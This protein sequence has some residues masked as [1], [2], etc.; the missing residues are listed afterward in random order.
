MNN[1]NDGWFF[2]LQASCVMGNIKLRTPSANVG[3]LL[4][5]TSFV[6]SMPAYHHKWRFLLKHRLELVS[7]CVT[8]CTVMLFQIWMV[9]Y[10]LG[11]EA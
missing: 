4:K 3:D 8:S 10:V 6:T 7:N 5:E 2:G 1:F 11:E 9:F